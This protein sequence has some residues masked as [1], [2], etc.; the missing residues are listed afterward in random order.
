MMF[1]NH[2]KRLN[3]YSIEVN[4]SFMSVSKAL[5]LIEATVKMPEKSN[6]RAPLSLSSRSLIQTTHSSKGDSYSF[7][8]EF[9]LAQTEFDVRPKSL[10]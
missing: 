8:W 3:Y 10:T 1:F 9:E 4:N 2:L 7:L 5:V 6:S